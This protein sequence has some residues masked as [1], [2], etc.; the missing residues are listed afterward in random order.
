MEKRLDFRLECNG[1]STAEYE[2][3]TIE[4]YN[5][6]Q[7]DGWKIDKVMGKMDDY[8]GYVAVT[9]G[10]GSCV[11]YVFHFSANPTI[12]PRESLIVDHERI[13]FPN[14]LGYHIEDMGSISCAMAKFAKLHIEAKDL[15]KAAEKEEV[16]DTDL[17]SLYLNKVAE[18][19]NMAQYYINK[20]LQLKSRKNG[21]S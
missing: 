16:L 7:E 11:E 17:E 2:R 6:S 13:S 3:K 10:N 1:C 4:E 18:H 9:L 21:R 19:T 20:I 15:E 5:K 8:D 14:Q 12:K